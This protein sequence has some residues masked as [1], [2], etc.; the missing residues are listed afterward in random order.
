MEHS[1]KWS[2]NVL[3]GTKL[4]VSLV[5]PLVLTTS[6]F[7]WFNVAFPELENSLMIPFIRSYEV[8]TRLTVDGDP[9]AVWPLAIVYFVQIDDPY[10][11]WPL[12]VGVCVQVG[13]FY[14]LLVNL[15]WMFMDRHYQP[16][17]YKQG[18]FLFIKWCFVVFCPVFP[19]LCYWRFL[20]TRLINIR[21]TEPSWFEW[22]IG[23][24]VYWLPYGLMSLA[25]GYL[26]LFRRTKEGMID[27]AI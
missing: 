17:Y 15:L 9:F 6:L 20:Y 14:A 21:V 10:Y 11:V 13:P 26:L 7:Y 25:L 12:T 23:Q 8:L 1:W 24:T 2:A 19:V 4:L 27:R 18:R 5:V 22:Y 3:T 16:K